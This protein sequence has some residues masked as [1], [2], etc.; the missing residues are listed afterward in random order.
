MRSLSLALALV[1]AALVGGAC[2]PTPPITVVHLGKNAVKDD[3]TGDP[4]KMRRPAADTYAGVRGGAYVVRSGEDWQAMWRHAPEQPTF[5]ATVDPASE[6]LVLVATEDAIVSQLTIKHAVETAEAVTVFVRQTMLGE[7]CVRR[8]DERPGLDAVVTRRVD[9]PIKFYIED[10]D[11]PSCGEPPKAEIGCRLATAQSWSAKLTAKT[12]DVIE[13]ELSSVATG[14]YELVD[15]TLSLV[16]APPASNAKLAFSK[17]PTRATIALDTFGT[18]A[19]RAEAT[20][21]AGR[22]GRAT[23]LIE[24]V[25]KKTRDVLLQL[26]WSDVDTSEL[27]TPLPRVL[28][29]VTQEGPRGQRCSAE[30]PVPG[31]CDAKSRGSYTYMKIPASRRKL[32][33]SLLYLDE[34]AQEGPTP[35]VNVWFNGERTLSMCDRDHRHAEDRWEIGTLETWTGKLAA[36]KPPPKPKPGAKPAS[37]ATPAAPG[38]KSA[39]SPAAAAPAP[40]GA[41][42]KK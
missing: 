40:A 15:Q 34:R 27:I 32:P 35:C 3:V 9:K 8:S 42:S 30:V 37:G 28:L 21:E 17:G 29:R 26:T 33:V 22:R 38:A 25:P 14:K 36:P 7:G 20:D 41:T 18:Y 23:A 12:G 16:D 1:F 5:P 24:V 2:V 13:C 4:V 19:V 31:L 10:E 39:P 6:M 11:G